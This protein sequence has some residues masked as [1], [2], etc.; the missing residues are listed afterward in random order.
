MSPG[1][2]IAAAC[3]ALISLWRFTDGEYIWAAVFAALALAN[4]AF[5]YRSAN[6]RSNQGSPRR[7]GGPLAVA[8]SAT[9]RNWRIIT[10]AGL[11][12]SV[13]SL[14]WFPPLALVMSG[15]TTYSALQLRKYRVAA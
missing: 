5:S 9:R 14:F 3:F 4:L 2:A 6:S 10:G 15:L 8:D 11:A 7:Q 1:S 13:A 12:L